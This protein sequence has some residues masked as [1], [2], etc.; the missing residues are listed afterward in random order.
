MEG[1]EDKNEQKII[2]DLVRR[3]TLS[4]FNRYY[5][6]EELENVVKPFND[7]FIVE[8]SDNM[9]ARSYAKYLKDIPELGKVVK[10]ITKEDA[11]EI[12]ASVIEFIF[13]GLHLNKR[14]NKSK[15]EGKTVYRN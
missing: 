5:R 10:K 7:G 2:T 1:F 4:V 11:P 12:Q 6:T 3:A 15:V 14:L 8:T 13:E 9:N